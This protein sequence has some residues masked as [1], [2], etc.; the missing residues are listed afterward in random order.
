MREWITIQEATKRLK[1]LIAEMPTDVE[2][3]FTNAASFKYV[4][5]AFVRPNTNAYTL[6]HTVLEYRKAYADRER[7]QYDAKLWTLVPR[8]N[9]DPKGNPKPVQD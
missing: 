8:R 4:A 9:D 1:Q 3:R 6:G 5:V 7:E 2:I